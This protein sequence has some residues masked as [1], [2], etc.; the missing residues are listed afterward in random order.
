MSDDDWDQDAA[1]AWLYDRQ[2]IGIKLGLDKVRALMAAVGD[3]QQSFWS[4]HVAGTN[5][6]GSVCHFVAAALRLSGHR[7]GLYTSPHLVR[8]QERIQVDGRPIP[9]EAI[10][11]GLA[12]LRPHVEA[13]D[14]AGTPPTFFEVATALAWLWFRDEGVDC[15]VVETGMGGRL[16]A[17]N[18][19]APRL[20]VIT[21]VS[22][23]HAA[24]LGP[25]LVSIAREKA[26]I[27]KPG[28]PCVTAA[29]GAALGVLKSRSL[30]LEVPMSIL[31]ED[32]HVEPDVN[33]L[34]LVHPAGAAHYDVA[35]AGEHQL[36]NA[37]VAVAACD[38][39]RT[40]GVDVPVSAVQAALRDVQVPGRLECFT[41][42][43]K[44]VL[45]DGAHNLAGAQTLRWHLGRIDRSGFDL[46]VGFAADK[47]WQDMLA[48]WAPLAVRVWAV[49]LRSPRSLDP[50]RIV[51]AL[52][53]HLP[54]QVA[55]DAATA[56]RAA[57]AAGAESVVVAGS[58]WLVGEAR[59]HLVGETLE[60]IRGAQ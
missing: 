21:N 35:A 38:A 40:R 1:L 27:M 55:P 36:E 43:G 18:I 39:L 2:R 52:P 48:Q 56:L 60:E 24:F 14:D 16:D 23:D 7:T 28:V 33:G 8:F 59:A 20:T 46:I 19:L 58:L 34:R 30:E 5:G 25:D 49:P 26:G 11:A 6:K 44:E 42:E 50:D 32:Y 31:G 47:A 4:V 9:P 29:A 13:L 12:R 51:A 37:A 41:L 17:T 10:A 57:V 54:A 53:V 22:D 15:A 3:P 45:I